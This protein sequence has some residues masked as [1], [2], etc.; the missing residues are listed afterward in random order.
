MPERPRTGS[1]VV[2][3][4]YKG[5]TGLAD[6]DLATLVDLRAEVVHVT[7]ADG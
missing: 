2:D 6:L 5:G 4:S 1:R 7:D 3:L